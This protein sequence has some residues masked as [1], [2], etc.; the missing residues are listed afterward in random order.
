MIGFERIERIFQSRGQTLQLGL[1][2]LGQVKQVAVVR[3]PAVFVGVDLVLDA[4]ETGHQERGI[5]EVG[6]AGGVGV[7][8]LE[9]AQLRGLGVRR[10]ANDGAAVGRGVTDGDGGLETGHQTLEGVGG[11]VGE[12]A[13]SRNVLQQT[14][15]EPVGFLAE[16]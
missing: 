1:F 5:A 15:H 2:L 14:A 10:N 6:I 13:Q 4:V 7:A 11:R 16:V 8:Q 9:A 3:T 12:G